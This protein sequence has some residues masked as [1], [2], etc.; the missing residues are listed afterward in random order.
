[1]SFPVIAPGQPP[2]TPAQLQIEGQ[3]RIDVVAITSIDLMARK[4]LQEEMPGILLRGMI[5]STAKAVAQSQAGENDESGLA[6]FAMAIGSII[7][8]SADE[9]GWRSLPAQIAIARARI[10]SGTHTVGFGAAPGQQGIRFSVSGRYAV[11]GIRLMN[12]ATFTMLPAQPGTE[13]STAPRAIVRSTTVA[14]ETF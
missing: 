7:T 4:A 1:V 6:A 9:R 10:P 2:Y 12:G 5:R 3:N 14:A 8:E 13:A 11:I